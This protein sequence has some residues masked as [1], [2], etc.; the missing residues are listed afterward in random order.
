M[1]QG[2][3]GGPGAGR[4]HAADRSAWRSWLADDAAT[5]GG[6]WL[7]YDKGPGRRLGYD[8]VV[9]EA[10]CSGWVDSR[11]GSLDDARAVL[12]VA[13]RRPRSNWSRENRERVA[14]LRATGLMTPAG[15]AVV[16][17]AEVSG[18]WTAPDAVE[19]LTEPDDLR[20][21]RVATIVAEA[22]EG[23]RANQWRQPGGAR[24]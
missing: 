7:V 16:A 12:D 2:R 21:A 19:D 23:R 10:L 15:E 6:V 4:V 20:A 3:A 18:A 5:S 17:A 9:E 11:P 8:D 13:P 1:G 14:R 22:A 24:R